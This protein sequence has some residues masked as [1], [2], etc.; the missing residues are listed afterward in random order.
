MVFIYTTCKNTDEAKSL[1]TMIIKEKLGACVDF[2]PIQ[3]YYNWEGDLKCVDQIMLCIT[4]FENKSED[5]NELI[6]QNHSYSVPMIA[7]TD[8]RRINRAY[9]E[10]MTGEFE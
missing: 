2:W 5:V 1:G 9:K 3:S 7:T 8:V 6:S 10:W 4:T